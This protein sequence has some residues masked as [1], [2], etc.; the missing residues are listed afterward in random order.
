MSSSRKGSIALVAGILIMV[1]AVVWFY[2]VCYINKF[3]LLWVAVAVI[4][5]FTGVV[6]TLW[7]AGKKP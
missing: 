7:G 4:L 3:D 1:L 6:L 2:D 5:F